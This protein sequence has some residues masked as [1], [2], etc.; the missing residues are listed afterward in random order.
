MPVISFDYDAAKI[1]SWVI[2]GADNAGYGS[3]LLVDVDDQGEAV[4]T[5]NQPFPRTMMAGASDTDGMS[6]TI[7]SA[8]F[9]AGALAG[10]ASKVE[11]GDFLSLKIDEETQDVIHVSNCDTSMSL[12]NLYDVTPIITPMKAKTTL[13]T[14]DAHEIVGA[15]TTAAGLSPKTSGHVD[16][17]CDEEALTVGV[18]S[19][20][21]VSQEVFPSSLTGDESYHLSIHGKQLSPLKALLKTDFVDTMKIKQSQGAVRLV[22]P[23]DTEQ[24]ATNEV[25]IVIPTVIQHAEQHDNPCDVEINPIAT[26]ART[27]LKSALTPLSSV[28]GKNGSILIDTKNGSNVVVKIT[29]EN[30]TAKTIVLDAEINSENTVEVSLVGLS[31]ALRNISTAE[32]V[33]GTMASEGD[34]WCGIVPDHE[35]DADTGADIIIALPVKE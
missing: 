5:T 32:I 31:M 29:D 23:I 4:I 15:L 28:V 33:V 19:D 22:F 14:V 17:H 35:D 16:I 25:S 18:S 24:T 3:M 20:M 8:A 9:P 30:N 6:T 12:T 27:A 7:L 10:I 1:L 11:E 34:L 21:I 13:A 2:S 26:I